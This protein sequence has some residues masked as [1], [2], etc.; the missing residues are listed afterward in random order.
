MKHAY[1]GRTDQSIQIGAEAFADRVV[2]RLHH[3]GE[4]FD[5]DTAPPPAFNGSRESGFGLY[6]IDQAV[7]EVRYLRD[8]R[9]RNCI[10]L[11]KNRKTAGKVDHGH[12]D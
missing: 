6:L 5:P 10:C 2:L 4:S 7:D 11:V 8:Q 9:G 3:L 12:D 1:K